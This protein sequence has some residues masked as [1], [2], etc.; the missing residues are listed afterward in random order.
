MFWC[1]I[2]S[3]FPARADPRRH[4][5]CHAATGVAAPPPPA[6]A[7]LPRRARRKFTAAESSQQLAAE[8]Q[9]VKVDEPAALQHLQTNLL[10]TTDFVKLRN[11]FGVEAEVHAQLSRNAR[12]SQLALPKVYMDH[13]VPE[14]S[15][16]LIC[17]RDDQHHS[18]EQ[19]ALES[20]QQFSG[21]YADHDM[22]DYAPAA[23][24]DE[25]EPSAE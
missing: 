6:R 19:P 8:D 18:H 25:P 21:G 24:V 11:L 4:C 7:L 23:P 12:L 17:T 2:A 22:A 16:W 20:E 10:L 13:F 1:R 5:H 9:P 15:K 3:P 14:A